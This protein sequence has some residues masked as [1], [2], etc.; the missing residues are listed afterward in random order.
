MKKCTKCKKVKSKSAFYH[1]HTHKDGL[2][3]WCKDCKR[4]F[5]YK[6]PIKEKTEENEIDKILGGYNITILNR[7]VGRECRYNIQKTD[8][9]LFCTNDK[10][11]FMNY[12][13]KI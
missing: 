6:R 13:S 7:A 8:G 11:K 5:Y 9:S 10:Q 1:N 2:S 3:S 12:L 4:E